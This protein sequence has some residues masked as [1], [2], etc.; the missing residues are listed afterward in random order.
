MTRF[1]GNSSWSRYFVKGSGRR[2][3]RVLVLLGASL[4]SVYG[5]G[6]SDAGSEAL[7]NGDY[8]AA[9][10]F[11]RQYVREHPESAEGLTNLG[12]ALQMQGK[13]TEAIQ[14]FKES[15]KRKSTSR[16]YALLAEEECKTR[17]L[18]DAR[19]IMELC[20]PLHV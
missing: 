2:M 20:R 13:S 9:E 10:R 4:S 14:D 3:S 16:A 8:K 5:Q 12:I 15:L 11:Y 18:S 6:T 17:N 19:P 1:E 7:K